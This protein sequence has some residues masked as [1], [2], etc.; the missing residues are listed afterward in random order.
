MAKCKTPPTTPGEQIAQQILN[1]YDIKSAEDVQDV[2]KQ[3]FGPIF[4]SMLK[5][6]MENHL[7]HK[8]HERSEDG[9]NVL[10][11]QTYVTPCLMKS[12]SVSLGD[13]HPSGRIGKQ[14]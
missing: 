11:C 14:L 10:V 13:F 1:N 5:G 3:I 9:D 2:L 6:E 4:E 7:G 8:K 12:W